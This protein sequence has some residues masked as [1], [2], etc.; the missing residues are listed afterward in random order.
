MNFRKSFFLLHV[1]YFFKKKTVRRMRFKG[2]VQFFKNILFM[3][4][5]K[6]LS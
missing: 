5:I 1:F 4:N 3:V 2:Y 6:H